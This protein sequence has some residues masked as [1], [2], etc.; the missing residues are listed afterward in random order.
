MR[1]VTPPLASLNELPEGLGEIDKN[2][3]A[4]AGYYSEAN[5]AS[6][7]QFGRL[8]YFS[9]CASFCVYQIHYQHHVLPTVW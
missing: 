1:K 2:I 9:Q 4:D 7:R 3:L 6:Y 5:A 8:L